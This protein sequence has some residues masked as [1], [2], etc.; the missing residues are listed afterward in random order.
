MQP[1]WLLEFHDCRRIMKFASWCGQFTAQTLVTTSGIIFSIFLR[2]TMHLFN[3][4]RQVTSPS[5]IVARRNLA[6]FRIIPSTLPLQDY[7]AAEP[8]CLAVICL[9]RFKMEL[10]DDS[11]TQAR[12]LCSLKEGAKTT[13]F[14][15]MGPSCSPLKGQP[16]LNCSKFRSKYVHTSRIDNSIHTYAHH[17]H[18]VM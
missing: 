8:L 1:L 17:T 6:K 14:H 7:C 3:F 18:N 4:I 16:D 2:A 11:H 9:S 13:W 5:S 15:R 10:W 12:E